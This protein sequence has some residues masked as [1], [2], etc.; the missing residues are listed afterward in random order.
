MKHITSVLLAG[1]CFM[2]VTA[3]VHSA[4]AAEE[5]PPILRASS[6]PT[7]NHETNLGTHVNT[8]KE[9]LRPRTRSEGDIESVVVNPGAFKLIM[10]SA[11]RVKS[12]GK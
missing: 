4:A 5:S 2:I 12:E 6:A 8:T 10:G 11:V 3:Q 1:F 7:P 9:E